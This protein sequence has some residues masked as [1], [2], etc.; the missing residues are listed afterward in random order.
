MQQQKPLPGLW[1]KVMKQ[2]LDLQRLFL[3]PPESLSERVMLFIML[4]V[5]FAVFFGPLLFSSMTPLDAALTA[6]P[7]A[8]SL[9]WG[10]VVFLRYRFRKSA[11]LKRS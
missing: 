4:A 8:L 2:E 9:S 5:T 11:F 10:W 6:M 7:P 3:S 1:L